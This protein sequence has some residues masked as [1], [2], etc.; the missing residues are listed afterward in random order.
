M[1]P[2][3]D[4]LMDRYRWYRWILLIDAFGLIFI[5]VID[6]SVKLFFLSIVSTIVH[7]SHLWPMAIDPSVHTESIVSIHRLK[8]FFSADD[9]WSNRCFSPSIDYRY[10]SNRCFIYHRCPTMATST[11]APPQPM[12]SFHLVL[13]TW[14]HLTVFQSAEGTCEFV[15]FISL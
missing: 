13:P 2:I 14:T 9:H 7:K 10:R 15:W 8:I 5:D 12:T 6:P 4:G 11:Y 3:G 1:G